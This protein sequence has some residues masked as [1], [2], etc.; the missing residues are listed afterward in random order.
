VLYINRRG[1]GGY[2]EELAQ[3]VIADW[4]G[5][6]LRD[7]MAALDAVIAAADP[8]IDPARLAITGSSYGGFMT[9]WTIGQTD[10]FAVAVAGACISNFESFFGTSDI[11]ASWG[12]REFGGPPWE[13]S[14]YYRQRSPVTHLHKA[15]TPLLLYHGEDD[16]RCPIEQSEQVFSALNALGRT[17][18]LIRLP[19]ESHGALAGSPVHRIEGRKAVLEWLDRYLGA[20]R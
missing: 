1:S 19:G 8:P 14:D 15:T 12:R 4:G 11:G 9:C 6:D 5:C 18:E 7:Q 13:R 10:R 3:A 2:G 16:L 17:V 20:G